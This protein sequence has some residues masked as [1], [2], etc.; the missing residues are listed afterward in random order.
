LQNEYVTIQDRPAAFGDVML[1]RDA[2]TEPLH[3]CVYIAD[4]IVFTKNGA[5][6]FQPWALMRYAD[7]LARYPDAIAS[8]TQL[9]RRRFW[10]ASGIT[11]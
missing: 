9:F 7:V 1:L 6:Y 8:Q 11:K 4:D 5:H 3:M 2:K 10:V